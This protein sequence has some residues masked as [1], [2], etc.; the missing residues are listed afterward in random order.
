MAVVVIQ[1]AFEVFL[2]D[3]LLEEYNMRGI[4][5]VWVRQG[6]G[7]SP[8]K[9]PVGEAIPSASLQRDLLETYCKELCGESVKD[10]QYYQCWRSTTYALRNPVIHSGGRD[11]TEIEARTAFESTMN[12]IHYLDD[13]LTSSRPKQ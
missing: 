10:N 11:V 8:V 7:S 1:S 6:K 4:P 13:L 3:R 12:Y 9:K 2:Q 5:H